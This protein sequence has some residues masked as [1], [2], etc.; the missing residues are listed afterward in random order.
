MRSLLYIILAPIMLF[1]T[2]TCLVFNEL[3]PWQ[4]LNREMSLCTACRKREKGKII[5]RAENRRE[6]KKPKEKRRNW[7]KWHK[8]ETWM[9]FGG[10]LN[11]NWGQT[12]IER[13][14]EILS[15]WQFSPKWLKPS[16]LSL[17]YSSYILAPKQ[18]GA[19]WLVGWF[20]S[21]H[22]HYPP[23]PRFINH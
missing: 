5:A 7:H 20:Q 22:A 13:S 4:P 8:G 9:G 16:V 21:C 23:T 11:E 14:E 17:L 1:D 12:H 6:Y 3:L 15:S 18:H 10:N 2:K 19:I